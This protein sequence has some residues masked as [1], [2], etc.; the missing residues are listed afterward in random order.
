[1]ACKKFF[2][3]QT[4]YQKERDIKPVFRM[5]FDK[6]F[7]ILISFVLV[8]IAIQLILSLIN[9]WTVS[10]IYTLAICLISLPVL[11]SR[12][13]FSVN[14]LIVFLL[15]F[16]ALNALSQII[17]FASHG[18]GIFV[19][20]CFCL[21]SVLFYG[22]KKAFISV[23]IAISSLL[24]VLLGELLEILPIFPPP[25][26]TPQFFIIKIIIF[27]LYLFLLLMAA[28]FIQNK[29][30]SSIRRSKRKS[31][32]LL[33]KNQE[34][35]KEIENR[36]KIEEELRKNEEIFR[37]LTESM[38]DVFFIQDLNFKM[39]YVSPSIEK[40]SG[41]S[42]EEYMNI[43]FKKLFTE[44]EFQKVQKDF[45]AHYQEALKHD[46]VLPLMEYSYIHKKGHP[47]WAELR[48]SFL[49]DEKKNIIAV[50]GIGREISDRKKAEEKRKKEESEKLQSE[51]MKLLGQLSSGITHDFNNQL[52]G[53]QGVLEMIKTHS[54][55]NPAVLEYCR[56]MHAQIK[57]SAKIISGLLVYSHKK[58]AKCELI[59]IV[60]IVEEC[61][62]ILKYGSDRSIKLDYSYSSKDLFIFANPTAIENTI[63]N[64]A[65]N[66]KDAITDH[67]HIFFSIKRINPEEQKNLPP[68]IS[69]S[70][71]HDY[72]LISIKD[73]GC[74]MDKQTLDKIY[75]P[76][77]TT[78]APGRGTGLGLA[79][80][81][82]SVRLYKGFIQIQSSPGQGTNVDLYFPASETRQ[83]Q[84]DEAYLQIQNNKNIEG[85]IL[86]VEDNAS[87]RETT[88]AFLEKMGLSV[89]SCPD[90]MDALGL[91]DKNNYNLVILDLI[92]PYISGYELF[93]RL[94]NKKKDQPILLCSGFFPDN[95][96]NEML[97]QNNTD[98]LPK[99]YSLIELNQKI[100][101]FLAN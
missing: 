34:L 30:S 40:F 1:M 54:Q 21:F 41:Y 88:Q 51:K 89:D 7:W 90:G 59:N 38:D 100:Q 42:V 65:I 39:L 17:L 10:G 83:A 52:A 33:K 4:D 58:E 45:K 27:C 87:V 77:F 94:R 28:F 47:I 84:K 95:R 76:F 81:Y 8:T 93:N 67:G 13:L 78:K 92:L 75:E 43:D 20:L 26:L 36:I 66:S 57:K 14:F 46:F 74:G 16:V 18:F 32:L 23:G 70:P 73:D 19:L 96:V 31:A 2:E 48:L 82:S 56:Q 35:H 25:E 3:L 15:A 91:I 61:I 60:D 62:S 24:L 99:P 29:W 98:F 6:S 101:A 12:K 64:I 55:D 68:E 85:K 63:L 80:V 69:S 50:I 37:F 79:A 97:S 72:I 9:G 49:R 71:T 53:I 44:K 86:Y 11:V 5:L 22:F